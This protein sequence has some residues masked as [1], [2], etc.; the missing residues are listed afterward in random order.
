MARFSLLFA[1][2]VFAVGC[3]G[4]KNKY[5]R[6]QAGRDLG[7]SESQVKLSTVSKSGAQYLA[8]ACGRRAVYTYSREQ[9]PVRISAIEGANVPADQVVLPPPV[10][11]GDPNAPPPPPPPPPPTP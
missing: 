4:N 1:L 6:K 11:S 3:G 5:I 9:G 10:G 8:E 2:V 7:C